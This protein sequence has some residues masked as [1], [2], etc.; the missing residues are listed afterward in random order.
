MDEMKTNSLLSAGGQEGLLAAVDAI[1]R[2]INDREVEAVATMFHRSVR[3]DFRASERSLCGRAM[4]ASH[5]RRLYCDLDDNGPVALAAATAVLPFGG[6][7]R[8]PCALLYDGPQRSFA[9]CPRLM[10][11]TEPGEYDAAIENLT[12]LSEPGRLAAAERLDAPGFPDALSA[13]APLR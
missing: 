4:V 6:H 8:Y 10:P 13:P 2:S 9:I 5:L 3:L 12:V 1:V 7:D 11:D